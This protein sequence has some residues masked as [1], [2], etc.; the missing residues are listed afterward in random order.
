M[1]PIKKK[2]TNLGNSK[3]IVLDKVLLTESELD[4]VQEVELVCGKDRI[5]IRKPK[6][7]KQGYLWKD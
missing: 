7:N 1:K 5:T 3:G 6:E 2:F 4:N